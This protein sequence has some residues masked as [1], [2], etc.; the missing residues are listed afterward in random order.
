LFNR[1][2]KPLDLPK[3]QAFRQRD[4]YSTQAQELVKEYFP[5]PLLLIPKNPRNLYKHLIY[6]AFQDHPTGEVGAL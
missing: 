1:S 5:P 6:K 2:I 3:R 4:R